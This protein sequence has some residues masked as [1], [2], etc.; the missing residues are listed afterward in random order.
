MGDEDEVEVVRDEDGITLT[1]NETGAEYYIKESEE[2]SEDDLCEGCGGSH[3]EE[4]EELVYEIELDEEAPYGGNKGDE[5]ESRRDYVDEEAPYGGNKG[6]ESR[7]DRDYV[8]EHQG[9]DDEEDESLGMRRGPER[10]Y[11]QSYKD[12]R[13]DS[14]GKWG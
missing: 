11:R 7:S 6:D 10:R 2:L 13:D 5:S 9:Y 3:V 4:D 8:E 1:D 12:R 14:Y